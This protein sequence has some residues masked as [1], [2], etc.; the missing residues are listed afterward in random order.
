M[1]R[2]PQEVLKQPVQAGLYPNCIESTRAVCRQGI[3]R[4]YRGFGA[5][6]LRDVPWNS[7]G[8]RGARRGSSG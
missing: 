7:L 3:G 6:V 4:L 5:T 2:V 8:E 1:I